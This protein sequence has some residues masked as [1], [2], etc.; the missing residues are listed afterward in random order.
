MLFF[1]PVWWVIGVAPIAVAG[2]ES[3]RHVYLASAGWAVVVA[4]SDRRAKAAAPGPPWR[5]LVTRRRVLL[6]AFYGCDS[7]QSLASGTPWPPSRTKSCVTSALK[8]WLVRPAAC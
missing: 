5:R 7:T 4:Y 3:P 6:L 2:Y 1:G 8:R